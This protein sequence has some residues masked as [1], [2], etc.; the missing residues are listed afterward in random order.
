MTNQTI[1]TPKQVF[2]GLQ[3]L[4]VAFGALVLMP[5]I[6]GL[7][8][9]TALLTAG[10]GTLLFQLCTKGQVPIFLASSFAFIAPIQYGVQQWG[11]PTTMGGL[12]FTGFVYFVLSSLVKWKGANI[13]E[14]LFPP[15]V[16]GPV[17]IIIGLGLAPTAVDM[18]LGKGTTIEP[19]TALLISMA[20]LITTLI[21]AVFAKGLMKLVPIMFGIVVGYILSLV[22]GIIDFS[23][24]T[25]AAWFSL[26][27]LT[28]PEF[29]LEAILYL[30]PIALAPAV[31]HVGGIMAI[32]SVTGKDFMNK[33][34]LHRTLLG[35]G[36]ATSAAAFLG[37]PPNTTY[38]EVTGAVM[39]TKNFNPRVMTFAAIWAIAISFCGKVGAFLQ[40][41]PG[42][43]MGGIMM[44]VFGSIAAVG[45]STLIRAK[46]DMGEARNLCIVS[47]VMAFGI[48]GMLIN[49]G[50]FSLKGI[51]LCA[52][53]AIV[54]NLLLPKEAAKKAE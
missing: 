17:I 6:T 8:P 54:M 29:K 43:V 44:L 32:S 24:V 13:L 36:V 23:P 14:K 11:I 16:V 37:G 33:P 48:G 26:P 18:A 5:L 46:V 1:S 53:A 34:G 40:T 45:M 50:E 19:N 35:D 3:M 25:N 31:E 2:V 7:D 42:V 49:V 51:S 21:V 9:N 39:L 41:I 4:F 12:V 10:I 27:K 20:T 47:V 15:V 38:A 52:I 22:F 28:T 30:L